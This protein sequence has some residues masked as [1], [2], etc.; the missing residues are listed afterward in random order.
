MLE[1]ARTIVRSSP[2]CI[3][4]MKLHCYILLL[5]LFALPVHSAEK[6]TTHSAPKS[7]LELY[8][9]SGDLNVPD[10]VAIT[11]DP[12]G[13]VYVTSTTRRKVGD[14]DIR[15][16]PMWIPDDVSLTSV[17]QKE[18]FLK[19]ELAPGK[20][21]VP[22]GGLADHNKDGS[23]DW[24]DLTVNSERIYQLRDTN[25]DGTAD[26]ITVFAEGFNSVVTGIAAGILYHDGWVYATIAP[27]LWRL[28]DTNDDGVADESD[29]VAH[30]F[31]MHIAYAGHDMHGPRIGPDGRIYWSI[32]DKGV[33]VT[34]KEGK[35]WFYPHEGCV[36]RC[37]PDG[38]GFE[39]F[40]HG[41]RNVQEVAFDDYGN[42]FG[43][44]ND[45]DLPGERERFVY[46]TELS[47]SGWRCS[48]QYQKSQSR[49]MKESLWKPAH[50]G[51][52]RFI[53]PPLANYSNGP[54]GFV[55][56]PGT[57]LS[58]SLRGHFVLNQFPS[59]QMNAFQIVPSGSSFRMT[60]E[61]L[62][63]GGTMGIGLAIT[64]DGAL[65]TADWDGGYPLD[66]KGAVWTADDPSGKGN[67][68]RLE[69]ARLIRAG[70]EVPDVG[71]LGH[72]DQRVRL[73]TQFSLV[74]KGDFAA[75][76]E[77]AQNMKSKEMARIHAIWG[78]G[79]GLR[80]KKTT[81]DVLT[82][83]LKDGNSEIITQAAKMIGDAEVDGASLIP[84]LS[85][86]SPR[87]RLHA[88]IALGKRKVAAADKSLFTL[89]AKDG[90]DPF[91]RHAIVTGLTGCAQES[92][93]ASRVTDK[94]EW[95]RL[96]SLLAL[97]RQGSSRVADFLGD[98]TLADDAERAIHDDVGIPEALPK[99]TGRVSS[100]GLNAC[101]RLGQP[102]PV[103]A[104]ALVPG[105][106]QEEALDVLLTFTSP[107]R[108]DRIDG[109]AHAVSPRDTASFAAHVQG[110]L[111]A[112][113]AIRDGNLKAKAVELLMQ[114]KLRVEPGVLAKIIADKTARAALRGEALKLMAAQHSS[115]SEFRVS[116]DLGMAKTAP[117][118]LRRE[119]LKLLFT[120]Q[121]DRAIAEAAAVLE[122]GDTTTKQL[123]LALLADSKDDALITHW[124]DQ[125]ILGKAP[126]GI[127]LDILEAAAKRDGLR[128]K[129]AAIPVTHSELLEGGSA[130]SGRD[131]V[132][133][134]LGANCIA[135][136]TVE[137]KEGSLVG[138]NL[139]FIGSQKDRKYILESLLNPSAVVAPG[140]GLVSVILKDGKNISGTLDREDSKQVRIRMADS[141]IK[142]IPRTQITTIT[143]PMSI[144]PPMLG[145]LSK[146]QVRD[147]VAYL[148]GLKA[149]MK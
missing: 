78:L 101:L 47:D 19:A 62:I 60:N 132:T 113:L 5:A 33:N 61:R 134:N 107:P 55:H 20:M 66:Q 118:E 58:A 8:R 26:Q 45:A 10:P 148:S 80:A 97:A 85:H 110:N 91:L 122:K 14:L 16:H 25:S 67:P 76:A 142:T 100:R 27:D 81:A 96:C 106:F 115:S 31:G 82:L 69:T 105:P 57:A 3:L 131:I 114:L 120:H 147:V 54:A 79:Q 112:L 87:V 49:W 75:L 121:P 65:I 119:A 9:W 50:P 98:P 103:V 99:L 4:S 141:S 21:R 29:I 127:Q 144:M 117:S 130:V 149:K 102:E 7:S 135:C 48:H 37:E 93:L 1:A 124:L 125:H 139:K 77:V 18:A 43:V 70:F 28:R 46:I 32:G 63:H 128:E 2:L 138:P 145:I 108:L 73:G 137:A 129:L 35:H 22:R 74:K 123:T 36:L 40:A 34:S 116:L 6:R 53:T 13:R 56:E 38:T 68:L 143:P 140:Y 83:L 24:K 11:V 111:D 84:L 59:G 51:Q 146:T 41:L 30:G 88:A 72:A 17:D 89:A 23:I 126:A 104:V 71:L 15:E 42:L 39:V 95:V 12:A 52:P 64:P 90:G 136:H 92:S 86:S 109:H 94:S 44:D 133:N